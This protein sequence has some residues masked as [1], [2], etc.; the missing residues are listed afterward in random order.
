MRFETS[1]LYLMVPPLPYERYLAAKGLARDKAC[2]NRHHPFATIAAGQSFLMP[3]SLRP[4]PLPSCVR[5]GLPR[6]ITSYLSISSPRP[7]ISGLA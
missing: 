6:K 5:I 1:C 2:Q 4:I 3:L 7:A